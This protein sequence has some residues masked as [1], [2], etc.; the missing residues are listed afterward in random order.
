M[1]KVKAREGCEKL[2]CGWF[3]SF[4][5]AISLCITL[6][7]IMPVHIG[8]RGLGGGGGLRGMGSAG[9]RRKIDALGAMRNQET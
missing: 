5:L 7:G 2:C 6:L 9:L 8:C 3:V 1:R 4:L